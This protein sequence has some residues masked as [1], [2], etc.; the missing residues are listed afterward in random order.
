MLAGNL[1]IRFTT[2]VPFNFLFVRGL[3]IAEQLWI[4]LW[5]THIPNVYTIQFQVPMN[6]DVLSKLTCCG[7]SPIRSQRNGG[8]LMIETSV[9]LVNEVLILS[10]III[11]GTQCIVETKT[12]ARSVI[13]CYHEEVHTILNEF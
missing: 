12:F 5:M 11:D 1:R 7:I 10:R 13:D 9:T 6:I 3:G 4:E 8:G 2:R